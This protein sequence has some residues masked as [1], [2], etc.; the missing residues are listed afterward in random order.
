MRCFNC[1]DYGYH[2]NVCPK[3]KGAVY[4]Y[5]YG[6]PNVILP[7]KF[8]NS[9]WAIRESSWCR[10]RSRLTIIIKVPAV[11]NDKKADYDYFK[12][13]EA[14]IF[15]TLEGKRPRASVDLLGII[16]VGLLNIGASCTVLGKGS[17]ELVKRLKLDNFEK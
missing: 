8:G 9:K 14:F 12:N 1:N 3:S 6:K 17:L 15:N 10:R 16:I 4:C 13:V 5:R 7:R 2:R 11:T